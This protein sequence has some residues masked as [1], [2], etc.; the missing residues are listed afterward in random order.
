MGFVKINCDAAFDTSSRR[1]GVGSVL[2]SWQGEVLCCRNLT[3]VGDDVVSSEGQAVFHALL[4]A[5]RMGALS[6]L[7]LRQI[8]L[9]FFEL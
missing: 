6:P 5:R 8:A 7:L 3:L 2:R 9:S 4:T 1:G